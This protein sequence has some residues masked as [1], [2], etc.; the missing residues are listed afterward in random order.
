MKSDQSAG[1]DL[2]RVA[3]VCVTHR[4]GALLPEFAVAIRRSCGVRVRLVF[5]DS[6]SPDATVDRAADADPCADVL[7]LTENHG[8]AA[9][10]NAG[11][12]H[13]R[14]TGGADVFV[15]ANP[16]IRPDPECLAALATACMPGHRGIAAPM[17]RNELGVRE[18]SLRR[19]PTIRA[20]WTV[21]ILGGRL[22]ERLNLPVE[23]V[24]DPAWYDAPH[25]VS[26]ATGGLLAISSAC[27]ER[28]GPWVEHFFM[29]EEEVEFCRRAA[30]A[31][32]RTWFVP[33]ARATRIA[34]ADA[35]SPWRY[36]LTRVNRV[37]MERGAR[38]LAL[39]TALLTADAV[40]FRKSG[41]RAAFRS[42]L[43]GATPAA[44][45]ARYR[46]D[47]RAVVPAPGKPSAPPVIVRSGEPL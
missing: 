11:I 14:V 32:F 20:S 9:G 1:F 30:A 15:V 6:G 8:F 28:V 35:E 2:P 47:A 13:V 29:Y 18:D 22:A 44:V 37:E 3:V 45:M 26:W 27:S 21:G 39:R 31:G 23:V 7:Q 36:A 12:A 19:S 25:E 40:R 4:S 16:D 5:V 24:R 42:V 41:A 38:R 17:M 34:G 10:I 43:T 46:P 33:S